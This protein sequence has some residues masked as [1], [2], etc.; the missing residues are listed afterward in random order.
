MSGSNSAREPGGDA[1]QGPSVFGNLPRSRPGVRSP[2]RAE[3]DPEPERKPS[4][5][6]AAAEGGESAE[7][8]I[9]ALARAGVSL[10]A[11]LATLGLRAAGRAAAT[12]RDAVERS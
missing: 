7:A 10:A 4:E 5:A 12:L 3:P 1:G 6:A 8:E 11:G 9:E 2:R